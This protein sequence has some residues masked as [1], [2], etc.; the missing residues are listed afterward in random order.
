MN[1]LAQPDKSDPITLGPSLERSKDY[2]KGLDGGWS[3][4]RIGV[5][6]RGAFWNESRHVWCSEKDDHKV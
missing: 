4:L 2:R 6:D 5:L 3:G 1:V